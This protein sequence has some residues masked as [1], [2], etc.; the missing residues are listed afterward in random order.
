MGETFESVASAANE[1]FVQQTSG[2]INVVKSF[3]TWNNL[4]K[5]I[6]ALIV[7]IILRI[8]YKLILR[9]FKRVPPEKAN[10]ARQQT[11]RKIVKYSFYIIFILYVLSLFGVKLS[12][13]WGAAG[14]AGVAI[15]FAAQTTVS[16]LISGLFVITEGSLKVGDVIIVGD[17][18]GVVDAVSLLS[19]RVHTFDNQMV[20][21]P[22]SSIINSNLVNNSY[23]KVRRL[24]VN[25]SIAYDTDMTLALET[26][27]KAPELCEHVLKDPAP[28]AWYDGFEDSGIK[29]TL[30]VWFNPAD[31]VSAK[32]ETY[33]AI[34]KV[35][36][37]AK[38]E[39]PYNK[40]DVNI[41]SENA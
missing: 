1:T 8:I 25:V 10:P 9:S 20:R 27:R 12:A 7:F 6:G 39:I 37:E 28:A 14:I 5:V 15:G 36:D 24:T 19:V 11:V 21:I 35:F 17:T 3:L 40:L 23:H 22:N 32:N 38:I 13:I 30:A 34:K 18:T 16:N 4:F 2:F 29:L 41:K 33:I 31:F 26:L